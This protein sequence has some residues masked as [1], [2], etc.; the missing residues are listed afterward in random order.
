MSDPSHEIATRHIQ[1]FFADM[2]Q[3]GLSHQEALV[4]LESFIVIALIHVASQ[5]SRIS[6]K[7]RYASEL[8]DMMT[9]A[10]AKRIND[11][12]QEAQNDE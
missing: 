5:D 2:V 11:F 9:E 7:K 12:Y 3:A 4:A 6:Q 1:G 10:A 8:L